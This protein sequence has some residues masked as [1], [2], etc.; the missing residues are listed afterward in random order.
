MEQEARVGK[1]FGKGVFINMAIS[2]AV[3]AGEVT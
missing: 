3:E 2:E 1:I